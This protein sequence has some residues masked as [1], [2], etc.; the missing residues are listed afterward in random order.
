MLATLKDAYAK[1]NIDTASNCIL[2]LLKVVDR[3][4]VDDEDDPYSYTQNEDKT[5]TMDFQVS[6]L[7]ADFQ[8]FLLMCCGIVHNNYVDL[9]DNSEQNDHCRVSGSSHRYDEEQSLQS[10]LIQFSWMFN[11]SACTFFIT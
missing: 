10:G 1:G 5:P 8:A 6:K 9:S 3:M 7:M 2:Y 11:C 4:N